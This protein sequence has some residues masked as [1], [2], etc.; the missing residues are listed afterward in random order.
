TDDG[1]RAT[2]ETL[3]GILEHHRDAHG[4]AFYALPGNHDIFGPRG[5]HHTK[6]FLTENGKC[7]SV[8]SDA[9]RAGDRVVISDRMYCEGYPA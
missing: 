8:S 6:E 4:T 2:S 9:R 7:L 5:R 3:K 1:Q